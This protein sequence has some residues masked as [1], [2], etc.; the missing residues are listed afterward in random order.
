MKY[1]ASLNCSIENISKY[2]EIKVVYQHEEKQF[3]H[4]IEGSSVEVKKFAR[5]ISFLMEGGS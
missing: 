4:I 3:G 5:E 1:L 2:I